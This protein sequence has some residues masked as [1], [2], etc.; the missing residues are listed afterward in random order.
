MNIPTELAMKIVTDMK[1]II[2][3]DLNFINTDGYIIAS[4]DVQRIGTIHEA[5]KKCIA[6]NSEIIINSDYEYKGCRKGI[7]IPVY[8]ENE[9]VGVIGITGERQDIE[10][11][12][13]IIKSMTEILIKEAWIGE[14]FIQKREQNRNLIESILFG[15]HTNVDLY[16]G[17]TFP[18]TVILGNIDNKFENSSS[19]YK[20]L[21]RFLSRNKK[22]FFTATANHIIIF[23]NSDKEQYIENLIMNIQ[24]ILYKN[25]NFNFKFGIGKTIYSLGDFTTS[26]TEA[27]NAL[28]Y[29]LNFEEDK[30]YMF[31]SNLDLGI[32]ISDIDKRR[33]EEFMEK[34]LGNLTEEEI[35]IFY[36]IFNI[37][38]KNNGS[39]K[40]ASKN[41][42]MHKNTLQYQLNKIEKLTGYNPRNLKDFSIL[43]LAFTLKK[44]CCTKKS[45]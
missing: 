31:Y 4:T 38:K 42:F 35:L 24:E 14:L 21:E 8:L 19:L 43:D 16:G 20:I 45:S 44:S 41:L 26:Y 9:I 39:I 12:G 18:Y 23:L 27:K 3:Q 25:L 6:L 29:I 40:E 36:N 10:K 22:N 33:A 30:K 2:N 15:E 37:Y 32:L 7:N 11:Y 34:I 13:K 1:N 28:K 17:L 5:S